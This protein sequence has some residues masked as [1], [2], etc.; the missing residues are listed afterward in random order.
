MIVFLCPLALARNEV[1]L[2]FRYLSNPCRYNDRITTEKAVKRQG[3]EKETNIRAVLIIFNV[4]PPD[5]EWQNQQNC[6]I[7]YPVDI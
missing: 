7:L 1:L 6:N 2:E 4:F 3:Q 5:P